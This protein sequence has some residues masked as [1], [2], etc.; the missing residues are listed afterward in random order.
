M[1]EYK[2]TDNRNWYAYD[3]IGNPFMH[4]S[5]YRI[6]VKPTVVRGEKLGAILGIN[7]CHCPSLLSENLRQ[8][9]ADALFS[10]QAQPNAAGPDNRY[11]VYMKG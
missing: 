7:D 8:Y 2:S 11:F 6:T 3:G 10:G 9:I 5:Y 4:T 1:D